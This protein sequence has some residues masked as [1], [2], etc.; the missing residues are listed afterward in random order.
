MKFIREKNP[1]GINSKGK[2]A[3]LSGAKIEAPNE[4]MYGDIY[5][6]KILVLCLNV[7]PPGFYFNGM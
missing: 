3:L 5:E 4:V 2:E 6:L 7:N 1:S